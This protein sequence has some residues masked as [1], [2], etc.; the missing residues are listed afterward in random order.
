MEQKGEEENILSKMTEIMIPTPVTGQ[1]QKIEL[2]CVQISF[3]YVRLIFKAKPMHSTLHWQM[4][5]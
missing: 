5:I 1:W 3:S 4:D 2:E